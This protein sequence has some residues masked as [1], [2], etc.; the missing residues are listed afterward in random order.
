MSQRLIVSALVALAATVAVAQERPAAEQKRGA[1]VVKYAAAKDLA[2]LLAKHFKGAAEIQVG[3]AG[4]SNCL[5]VN[6]PPAVFDEVMKTLEQLD[7][8]PHSVAVEVFVIELPMKKAD[9][10]GN[11]P[12][13]RDFSGTIDDVAGRLDAMMKNG[14]VTGVKRLRLTTLEGQPGSLNQDESKPFA[15][16]ATTTTYRNVG[17]H[18]KVTPEVTA[19]GSVTLDLSVQDSHV[20]DSADQPGKPE[21]VL[22]SLGAKMSLAPGKAALVKD[23]K[24]V[25]K[26]GEGETCI[27]VGARVNEAGAGGK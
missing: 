19:D 5:L 12:D 3:P 24:V 6:A 9:D 8:R 21:F 1:Y 10:K 16:S 23:A 4:T 25:S 27:V 15:T 13:E 2:G 26:A 18:I 22:T 7:R 17:T 14:Q 20:R 11:R